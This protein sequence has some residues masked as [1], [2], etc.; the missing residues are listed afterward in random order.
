MRIAVIIAASALLAACSTG[1]GGESTSTSQDRLSVPTS[2]AQPSSAKPT[3]TTTTPPVPTAAPPAGT[4]MSQVI[5]WVE[6]G[7]QADPAGFHTATRGGETTNLGDDVAFVTT[8]GKC[9]TDKLVNG[10]LACLVKTDGLPTK[11]SD[12]EGEW[13]AGWVDFTGPTLE[14]GS[15]HGDPGRFTYGDGAKLPTGGSI[16]FG[17]YRCRADSTALVCVNYAH[18]SGMRVSQAGVEPLGCLK[19]TPPAVGIGRQFS[20]PT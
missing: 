12:V 7:P 6:A 1:G 19:P 18:Q 16:A 9:A 10:Q 17:D 2:S 20:C 11:P 3:A 5:R 4:P 8:A 13:I 14:V 15:L